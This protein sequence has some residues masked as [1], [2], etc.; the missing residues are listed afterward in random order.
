MATRLIEVRER[1][2]RIVE[3]GKG[4]PLVYL[5][6]FADVHSLSAELLP[7]HEKLAT[8]ARVI[9]PAHPGCSTSDELPE[10]QWAI[11]NI[12][13]HV[14][15]TLDT[16]GIERFDLVGHCVGGWIAAELA[17]LVPERIG[18]LAL[19]G[20]SGLFVPGAPIADVFMHAQPERGVDYTTLRHMLFKSSDAPLALANYPDVRGDLDSEVRRYEMLRFSSFVGFKPP[21]F[22]N[23][24]LSHQLHRARMPAAVIWGTHDH[25]V[26]IAHAE[27]YAAG[28][29]GSG[30]KVL[31]VADAGHSAPL[32]AAEATATHVLAL[33]Q[34]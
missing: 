14:L 34:R 18:H 12:V 17:T 24:A 30:G 33:L 16:L 1:K 31:K 4:N 2:V 5:H 25:F 8:A 19:I 11:S 23:R 29:S 26:P 6:G 13:F 7:F 15:E 10:G 3:A 28:L 27:A 22:Y 20:A 21:Y 9:A 32:E